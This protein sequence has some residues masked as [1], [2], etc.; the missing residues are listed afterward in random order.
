VAAGKEFGSIVPDEEYQFFTE[1]FPQYGA[2][3]WFINTVLKTFN[4]KVRENPASRQ[5]IIEAVEEMVLLNR[6][7]KKTPL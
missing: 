7:A 2:V 6:E 5:M 1:N 3:K 4:Q